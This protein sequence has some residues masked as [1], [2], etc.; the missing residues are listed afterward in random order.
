MN[1]KMKCQKPINHKSRDKLMEKKKKKK[2]L[3]PT[4]I[5]ND[6]KAEIYSKRDCDTSFML[7]QSS[8]DQ[9]FIHRCFLSYQTLNYGTLCPSHV[10]TDL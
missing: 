3:T 6:S 9:N 2:S 7:L 10:L 5:V 4:E 1:K 8:T